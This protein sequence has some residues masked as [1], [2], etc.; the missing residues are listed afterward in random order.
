MV[1]EHNQKIVYNRAYRKMKWSAGKRKLTFAVTK[2]RAIALLSL[3]C[4]YCGY[5]DIRTINNGLGRR[6]VTGPCNGIDRVDNSL[7]YIEGNMVPCCRKCNAMKGSL[8]AAEFQ[9][10]IGKIVAHSVKQELDS[11]RE[12]G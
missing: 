7:G 1:V 9:E 12:G 5:M 3:P 11:I 2:E 8:G 6:T 4:T 10:W